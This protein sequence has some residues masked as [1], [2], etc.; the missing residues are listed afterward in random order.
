[1]IPS[2]TQVDQALKHAPTSKAALYLAQLHTSDRH[3]RAQARQQF[4]SG[5]CYHIRDSKPSQLYASR[6]VWRHARQH[7]STQANQQEKG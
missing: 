3:T 6:I 2:L 5:I 1:V 7:D 4:F